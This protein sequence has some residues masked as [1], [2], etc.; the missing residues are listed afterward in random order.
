MTFVCVKIRYDYRLVSLLNFLGAAI[1]NFMTCYGCRYC[2]SVEVLL[3]ETKQPYYVMKSKMEAP[4]KF[5]SE[6]GR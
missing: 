5:K 6:N 1:L 3:F 2:Y 4:G